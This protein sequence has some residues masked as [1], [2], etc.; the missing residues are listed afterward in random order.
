MQLTGR[1]NHTTFGPLV[2]VPNLVETPDLASD[3]EVAARLLAAFIKSKEIAIK[4]ALVAN[5]LAAARRLV[6][7][8][9]NG[10]DR[11]TDP[12]RTGTSLIMAPV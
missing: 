1:A 5:H 9:S 8:G 10:L 2:G 11:F 3:R 7:G 6:N 4:Q 12:Y